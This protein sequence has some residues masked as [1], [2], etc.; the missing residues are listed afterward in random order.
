VSDPLHTSASDAVATSYVYP[1]ILC[2]IRCLQSVLPLN[3]SITKLKKKRPEATQTLRAGCSKADPQTHKQTGT[4]TI[5]RA[6][7][8]A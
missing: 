7:L 3:A 4:I 1:D 8:A 6:L 5:H 2:T